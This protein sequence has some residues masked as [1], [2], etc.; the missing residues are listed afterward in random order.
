MT[1][2][3]LSLRLA[4]R[5]LSDQPDGDEDADA[6]TDDDTELDD[7]MDDLDGDEDFDD[8]GLDA[9]KEDAEETE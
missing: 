5:A 1:T 6:L 9:D 4:F 7:D 2:D 3:L 8:A